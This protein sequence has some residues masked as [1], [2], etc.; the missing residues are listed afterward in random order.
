MKKY[1]ALVLALVLT[2]TLFAG[3]S[4]PKKTALIATPSPHAEILEL[5]KEALECGLYSLFLDNSED[6]SRT[7]DRTMDF[8]SGKP[9]FSDQVSFDGYMEELREVMAFLDENGGVFYG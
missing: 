2:A 4:A 9:T 3:C 6:F 8:L 5:I 7:L 1:L